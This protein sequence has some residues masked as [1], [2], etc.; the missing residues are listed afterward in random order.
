MVSRLGLILFTALFLFGCVSYKES[1]S[2]QNEQIVDKY[3]FYL[4][5]HLTINNQKEAMDILGKPTEKIITIL[6][7]NPKNKEYLEYVEIWKWKTTERTLFIV[8]DKKGNFHNKIQLIMMPTDYDKKFLKSLKDIDL[9][10]W[11]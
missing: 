5:N 2:L 7:W 9:T 6:E 1:K 11:Y 8:F 10:K 4:K 3:T